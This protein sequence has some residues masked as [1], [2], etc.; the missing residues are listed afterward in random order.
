MKS[1]NW[2]FGSDASIDIDP[3]VLSQAQ[4]TWSKQLREF[5][6]LISTMSVFSASATSSKYL[7][8]QFKHKNS[9]F[10]ICRVLFLFFPS[11]LIEFSNKHRIKLLEK[12]ERKPRAEISR[13]HNR[14]QH[15]GRWEMLILLLNFSLQNA[16]V[17]LIWLKR[18]KKLYFVWQQCL[19]IVDASSDMEMWERR[20]NEQIISFVMWAECVCDGALVGDNNKNKT[21]LFCHSISHWEE[22]SINVRFVKM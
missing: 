22:I 7:R 3:I 17:G 5:E 9:F 16:Y 1:L 14:Q 4:L 15:K 6:I 12:W 21:F 18:S 10:S 2:F 11:L 20:A 8:G 13:Q 19:V